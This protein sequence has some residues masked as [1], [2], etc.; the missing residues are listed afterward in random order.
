[1]N[2]VRVP[3][4]AAVKGDDEIEDWLRQQTEAA[5]HGLVS[6]SAS[7]H[8]GLLN[9]SGELYRLIE[10]YGY[11]EAAAVLQFLNDH[12]HWAMAPALLNGI[13]FLYQ[14]SGRVTSHLATRER[15]TTGS[16]R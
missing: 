3:E 6:V 13:D 2:T 15:E 7:F 5:S 8:F 4:V 9:E 14:P 1:M 16:S 10:T 12:P 11:A